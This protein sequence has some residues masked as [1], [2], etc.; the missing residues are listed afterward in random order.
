MLSLLATLVILQAPDPFGD[1]QRGRA[2]A[3]AGDFGAASALLQSATAAAPSWGLAWL[4]LAEV[5]LREGADPQ[6]IER[7][8]GAARMLE[9]LNPRSWLL[10]GRLREQRGSVDAALEAYARASELRGTLVEA[11][12]RAG[13]L[14]LSSGRVAEA[15]VHLKVVADA[16]PG[17]RAVRANLAEA[18][19]R[20]GD[21]KQAEAHLRAL[22]EIAPGTIYHR[23]LA[24]FYERTG[25]RHK[26]ELE[27][28][29]A[30]AP[31]S[32]RRLRPL[33][34]SAR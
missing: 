32:T 21:L 8:L 25:Q 3:A 14:L 26:A 24:S 20:S 18:Y 34:P 13:L 17:D 15:L 11:R 4:E 9:P 30:D 29:K 31:R 23:R 5:Q 6:L 12:E 7:S 16:D 22:A 2:A 33:P 28:R 1:L 19:E 10:T 27:L